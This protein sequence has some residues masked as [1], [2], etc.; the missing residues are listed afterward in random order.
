MEFIRCTKC[1]MEI[2]IEDLNGVMNYLG[3][4]EYVCEN[5]RKE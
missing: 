4:M 5:C 2:D 1:G 3:S